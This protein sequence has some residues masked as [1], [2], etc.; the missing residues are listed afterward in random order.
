MKHEFDNPT[1]QLE[2]LHLRAQNEVL[3]GKLNWAM[4]GLRALGEIG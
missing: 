1:E 2:I 3:Q 4:N